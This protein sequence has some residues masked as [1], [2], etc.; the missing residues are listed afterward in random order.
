MPFLLFLVY[1]KKEEETDITNQSA[2]LTRCIIFV[3]HFLD[4]YLSN[5]LGSL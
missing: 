4:F 2:T 5:S 1:K 3:I